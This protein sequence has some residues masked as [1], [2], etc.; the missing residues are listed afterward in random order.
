VCRIGFKEKESGPWFLVHVSFE[1]TMFYL[2]VFVKVSRNGLQLLLH[3][4]LELQ[5]ENVS[6]EDILSCMCVCVLLLNV[7]TQNCWI[8]SCDD[9]RCVCLYYF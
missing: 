5:I 3:V 8:S 4:H 1:A 7:R 6:L 2:I 9:I